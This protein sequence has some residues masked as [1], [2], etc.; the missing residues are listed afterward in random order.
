MCGCQGTN[1]D[2]SQSFVDPFPSSRI[3]TVQIRPL[4]PPYTLAILPLD[5]LT[6]NASLYWLGKSLSEMLVNDLAK[7]PS[8]F[9]IAREAM[10]PVLREQWLQQRGFSSSVPA[11]DLGH[12][13]GVRYVVS[14]G[15]HQQEDNLRIDLQIIDVETGVVVRSLSAQGQQSDISRIEQDLVVQM[16]NTFNPPLDSSG[17]FFSNQVEKENQKHDIPEDLQEKN[18]LQMRSSGSFGT[19]S[20]L[21][22]DV[23]L[24]LEQMTQYRLDAYQAAVDF[25]K[26]GWSAEMGKP[27]YHVW[28]SSDNAP[29][30][31]SILSLPISLF[32]QRDKIADVVK[33]RR[34]GG[35]SSFVNLERDGFSK[36]LHDETGASQLFFEQV[37]QPRRLFVRALNEKGE[38]VA[39]Y[40][41]WSWQTAEIL[42]YSSLE[43]L[44]FPMWPQPFISGVAEFPGSWIERG[45]QHLSFDVVVV[46]IPDE[47]RTI[48][49]E[50]IVFSHIEDSEG[51]VGNPDDMEF[52]LPLK[53][54]IE[55]NWNPPITEALPVQGYLPANKQT[56]MALLNLQAGKVLNVQFQNVPRDPLFYRSLEELKVSLLG[57][58][59]DCQN[60][61]KS[62]S[63]PGLQTI[64]LQLTL[65]KDLHA[66]RFGS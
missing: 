58:C 55:L 65:G 11:I 62:S 12:I 1:P 56:V 21:Q 10:G 57:Y 28:Q 27:L 14:G 63:G 29:E 60:S 30:S 22:I 64:R 38:L 26:K 25:W 36:S 13:Q 44:H 41:K 9:V 49:L 3:D 5:N 52:L 39:V 6:P 33:N 34:T 24:A 16:F 45:E 51:L 20:I 18:R 59:V 48:V 66:L 50:P 40:S 46:P 61:E 23:Q 8:L 17:N 2:S 19:H 35:I 43:R 37:R 53:N 47:Q 4:D 54:V 32:I 7:R 15:F 31:L 42:Q